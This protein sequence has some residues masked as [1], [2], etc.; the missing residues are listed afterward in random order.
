MNQHNG[1]TEHGP[2]DLFAEAAARIQAGESLDEVVAAYPSAYERVLR[3]LLAIVATATAVQQAPTPALS[4][5][6]QAARKAAFLH[7]AAALHAEQAALA[8]LQSSRAAPDNRGAAPPGWWRGLAMR[9]TPRVLRPLTAALAAVCVLILL[10]S[11]VTLAMASVPGDLAYPIKQ[12]I[13]D[14]QLQLAP[15]AARPEV[16]MRH[17]EELVSDVQK[18]QLKVDLTRAVIKAESTLLYHGYRPLYL[19]IGNL[20]VLSVYQPDPNVLAFE[21]MTVIGDLTPGA[22]VLL[23]YQILPGQQATLGERVVQGIRLEVLA[24]QP[25]EPTPVPQEPLLPQPPPGVQPCTP[26]PKPGWIP[27][28]V[29][30]GDTLVGFAALT[31]A[32]VA[33]LRTVNCLST[34]LILSNDLLLAPA[35]TPPPSTD[36]TPVV[37]SPTPILPVTPAP[38]EATATTTPVIDATVVVSVT[39]QPPVEATASATLTP[40]VD[41]TPDPTPDLTPVITAT[42]GVTT[43]TPSVTQVISQTATPEETTPPPATATPEP[44]VSATITSAT[45]D[46]TPE[47][48]VSATVTSAT[49][50]T[51]PTVSATISSATP[52]VTSEPDDDLADEPSDAATPEADSATPDAEAATAD[53][54]DDEAP[55]AGTEPTAP[56]TPTPTPPATPTEAAPPADGVDSPPAL[57]TVSSDDGPL[58]PVTPTGPPAPSPTPSERSALPEEQPPPPTPEE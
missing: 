46:T 43:P 55:V 3:D 51:T 17:E 29:R 42:I 47:P 33:E 13:R 35:I 18:T 4:R 57:P 23:H 52:G 9:L 21:Q 15:D 10:N 5:A 11:F 19:M 49:P 37:A 32:S 48:T 58:P 1:A 39:I 26:T 28:A 30:P 36:P 14:Q 40:T 44:T 16:R 12:W 8:R 24:G 31:G 45:P 53:A 56:A 20:R 34:D 6:S 38:D 25:L 50:D 22:T 41:L 7:A 54:D 2:D 27:Y